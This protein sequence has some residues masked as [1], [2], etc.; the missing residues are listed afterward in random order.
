MATVIALTTL[1]VVRID[2]A[3]FRQILGPLEEL[4]KRDKSNQVVFQKMMR[5]Q[6]KTVNS[7]IPA[8]VVIKRK[9][10]ASRQHGARASSCLAWDWRP[11]SG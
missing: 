7:K 2:R 5:L 8:E 4:M 11:H 1:K 6:A 3:T 9:V 10:K